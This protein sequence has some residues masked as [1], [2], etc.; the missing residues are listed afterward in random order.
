[1]NL[2]IVHYHLNR[3]GVTRVI[4]NQLAA[5][6]AVLDLARPWNVA[7]LCGGRRRGWDEELAGRLRAVRLSVVE[8]PL[9]DYDDARGDARRHS[10]ADLLMELY[11]AL[12]QLDF[13]PQQTVLHFHNHS[14]GKNRALPQVVP[15]LAEDGYAVLLQIHDFAE[16]F[17]SEN[18]RCLAAPAE[19][20]PQSASIHYAALNGRDHGVLS[21]AGIAPDRLH[22]LPNP[23]PPPAGLPSKPNARRRLKDLFGVAAED[24]FVLYPVR[25]IR[26]KNIGEALLHSA[27]APPGT[28]VGLT[29]APLSPAEL[30]IYEHWKALAAELRLPCLFELGE[31]GALDFAENLAGCDLML[32]TS[33]AEGFG[34]V[35]L[36]SWL[37]GRPLIGRDL[38]AVTRDFAKLG[39]H[40]RSLWPRL[41]VPSKWIDIDAFRQLVLD[42]FRRTLEAYG[43]SEQ[44]DLSGQLAAKTADG[45]VDFGDLDE[46]LQEQVIR[47]VWQSEDDRRHLILSNRFLED[48]LSMRADDD[49]E[50]IQRNARTIERHFS[51]V[52]SGRRLLELYERVVASAR[53]DAVQPV[54]HGERILD[55]FLDLGRF[56][57]IR[58]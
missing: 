57:L 7:V 4:E 5:L 16:D 34:M 49:A 12:G 37:A 39:I 47:R 1:M 8:V 33:L 27:L 48:R 20:Y 41:S 22:L 6:D 38:P 30:A 11:A 19:I 43:R 21:E 29:L 3:G 18:Y 13:D 46:T 25:C 31:S 9:L 24:H 2:A 58:S 40:L 28:V 36:E 56:R 14:L 51:P 17:R 55:R 54:P 32:T 15:V 44:N 50:T 45:F 35:F 52:P 42:T 26:R 53:D 10:P 23:V